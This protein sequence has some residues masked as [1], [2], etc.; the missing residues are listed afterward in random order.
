MKFMG[1]NTTA[2]MPFHDLPT[3]SLNMAAFLYSSMSEIH[4]PESVSFI[5]K[6]ILYNWGNGTDITIF[7]KAGSKAEQYAKDNQLTFREV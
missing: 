5:G 1:K 4:I 6:G 3:V 2:F 7:G